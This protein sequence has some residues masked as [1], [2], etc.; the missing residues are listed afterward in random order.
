M[1]SMFNLWMLR[2]S[3]VTFALVIN[4]INQGRVP[5]HITMG[6][7]E[8]FDIF[9]A[10]LVHKIKV[11]L[12]EFNLTNEVIVKVKD[13]RANLNSLTIA[14]IFICCVGFYFS[15]LNFLTIAFIFVMLCGP[16]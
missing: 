5:C 11:L 15:H 6:S 1:I 10:T 14:F 3:Y 13:V 9:S 4:F 2:S 8:K 12:I 16:L 7:F